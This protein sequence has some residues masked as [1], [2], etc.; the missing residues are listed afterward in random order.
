METRNWKTKRHQKPHVPGFSSVSPAGV[1][2]SERVMLSSPNIQSG[3]KRRYPLNPSLG[4][5]C[6]IACLRKN[7]TFDG[8]K[9]GVKDY[10]GFL[11]GAFFYDVWWIE[12]RLWK[13]KEPFR[14]KKWDPH[15]MLLRW[16]WRRFERRVRRWKKDLRSSTRACWW[17]Y[18]GRQVDL[19]ISLKYDR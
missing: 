10:L 14:R 16:W 4:G 9:S 18:Y 7:T 8:A 13:A 2:R 3:W 17:A 12:S 6:R 15:L 11:T 19:K 1:W 5:F